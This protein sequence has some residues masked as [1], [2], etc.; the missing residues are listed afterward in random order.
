M[1]D[2]SADI[3]RKLLDAE[4]RR[5][6]ADAKRS[7]RTVNPRDHALRLLMAFPRTNYSLEHIV[8]E[9]VLIAMKADVRVELDRNDF[10]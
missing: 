8:E 2:P 4:L 5:I 10:E 3:S 7:G 6:V 1:A 9:M